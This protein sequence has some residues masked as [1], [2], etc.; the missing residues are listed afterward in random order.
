MV[1]IVSIYISSIITI[2]IINYGFFFYLLQKMQILKIQNMLIIN[3]TFMLVNLFNHFHHI[4]FS[5]KTLD[6]LTYFFSFYPFI[7]YIHVLSIQQHN[8]NLIDN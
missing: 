6:F 4:I 8:G 3:G 5:T 1:L 2:N 7:H